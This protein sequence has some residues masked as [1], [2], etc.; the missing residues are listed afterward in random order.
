[1]NLKAISLLL[2]LLQVA[3]VIVLIAFLVKP[4]L[5]ASYPRAFTGLV[6]VG[7]SVGV[8]SFINA[9]LLKRQRRL[10]DEVKQR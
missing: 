7:I 5:V 2:V 9:A 1:M 10:D 8:A 4:D 3:C 6:L